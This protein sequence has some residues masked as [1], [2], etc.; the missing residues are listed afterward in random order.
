M[1]QGKNSTGLAD[2]IL[3][4]MPSTKKSVW[5]AVSSAWRISPWWVSG[6]PYQV[7]KS[8]E[9]TY[10]GLFLL[11]DGGYVAFPLSAIAA[12]QFETDTAVTIRPSRISPSLTSRQAAIRIS[13]QQFMSMYPR[14]PEI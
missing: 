7:Y 5:T 8:A 11:S 1:A 13:L 10:G 2:L 9:G 4:C 3:K 12:L 6:A 14:S